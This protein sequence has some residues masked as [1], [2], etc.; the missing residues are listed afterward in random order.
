MPARKRP[1]TPARKDP[2]Y[3]R[4]SSVIPALAAGISP[5]PTPSPAPASLTTA[6]KRPATPA[7]KSSVMPARPLPSYPRLPR[8]SRRVLHRAPRPPPPPYSVVPAQNPAQTP[9]PKRPAALGC[10]LC[11]CG[12]RGCGR[13]GGCLVLTA[14]SPAPASLTP[15]RKRP[16]MPAPTAVIPALAAGMTEA[17]AGVTDLCAGVT[18]L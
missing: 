10:R 17:G 4:K 3:P 5:S 9:R 1:A 6:R 16:A 15:A 11:E 12:G 13:R 2:S 14:P 18:D 8:V 7:R